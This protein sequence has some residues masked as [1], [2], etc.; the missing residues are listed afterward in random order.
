MDMSTGLFMFHVVAV[1]AIFGGGYWIGFQ[2]GRLQPR[3]D[4]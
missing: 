3:E 4:E 2:R 1:V